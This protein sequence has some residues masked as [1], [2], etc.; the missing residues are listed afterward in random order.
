MWLLVKI[1]SF[2]K[3]MAYWFWSQTYVIVFNIRPYTLVKGQ[4]IVFSS[5]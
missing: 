3:L 4:Q 5:D 1:K 2:I